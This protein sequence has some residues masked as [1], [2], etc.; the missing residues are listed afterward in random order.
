MFDI[1]SWQ[2]MFILL[3]I[4]LVVVGPKDLPRIMHYLGKWAAKAKVVARNV[5]KTVDD[6]VRENELEELRS[7]VNNL[8][9]LNPMAGIVPNP[10]ADLKNMI[11]EPV[12]AQ[13]AAS[14]AADASVGHRPPPASA[15]S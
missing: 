1:F 11:L 8:R 9:K 13:P 7:E 14:P 2:H 4:A 6:L 12:A 5:R 3:V 15:A 10:V